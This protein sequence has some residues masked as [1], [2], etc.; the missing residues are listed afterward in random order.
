MENNKGN[1]NLDR[2]EKDTEKLTNDKQSKSSLYSKTSEEVCQRNE[3]T[4]PV[5]NNGNQTTAESSDFSPQNRVDLSDRKETN[6]C[7]RYYSKI[8]K[9]YILLLMTFL[10]FVHI[11]SMRVNLNVT[12]VA[13]VNNY[14][15]LRHGVK[16]ERVS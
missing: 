16:I 4:T 6:I 7:V 13:M 10:G 12:L 8:P 3:L 2:S 1:E 14:T 11:Y 9:R 5:Q 15:I